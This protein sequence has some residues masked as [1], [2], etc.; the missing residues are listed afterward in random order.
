L[1]TTGEIYG[2]NPWISGESA[3]RKTVLAFRGPPASAQATVEGAADGMGPPVS[4]CTPPRLGHADWRRLRVG[5]HALVK[6]ERA[7][8]AELG[9]PREIR[10]RKLFSFLS[11]FFY[12]LHF[13]LHFKVY[14]L[15]L[16][17]SFTHRLSAQLKYQYK[18]ICLFIYHDYYFP[19]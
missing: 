8:E 19:L 4:T 12:V 5:A 15:N 17:V 6:Q 13:F 9:R 16:L 10:P 11:F 3:A 14:H 2:Q 18:K 1:I 7:V